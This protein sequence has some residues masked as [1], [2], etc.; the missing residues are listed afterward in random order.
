MS[1]PGLPEPDLVG[2]AF[3]QAWADRD[4]RALADL[5]AEDADFVNVVGLWWRSRER[6]EQA[7]AYGFE[8]I[9]AASTMTV[10]APRTRRLGSSA[11][12][13]HVAWTITGQTGP[14]GAGAGGRAGVLVFVLQRREDGR[15]LVVTAQNTDRVPGADSLVTDPG[16]LPGTRPAT[17]RDG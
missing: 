2:R 16:G 12:V 9:F 17:Y 8:R 6:I 4:A 10:R 13:V 14:Q 15:W 3:A 5:F 7:H 11:A 1:A